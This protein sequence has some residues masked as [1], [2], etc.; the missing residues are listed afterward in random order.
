MT[1]TTISPPPPEPPD[2]PDL[3]PAPSCVLISKPH[4]RPDLLSPGLVP[5][6]S[7][8]P[9]SPDPINLTMPI[10]AFKLYHRRLSPE[11][12]RI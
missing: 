6:T 11:S 4:H 1:V 10:S 8:L 9:S 7:L 3:L 12:P 5:R 2:T